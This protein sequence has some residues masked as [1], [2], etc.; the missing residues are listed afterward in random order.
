MRYYRDFEGRHIRLT[1]ERLAHILEHPEMA[2]MEARIGETIARPERVVESLS[3]LEARL[4]YRYY[5]GTS[6]GNKHLAVVVKLTVDDAF[7]V[8]AYLTDKPKSGKLLW[9]KEK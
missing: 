4:Y 8:T 7:V 9:P 6:V 5:V 2:G 3:D 1:D